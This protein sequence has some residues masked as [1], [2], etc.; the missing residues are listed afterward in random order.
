MEANRQQ[1]NKNYR[2]EKDYRPRTL[3]PAK[4]SFKLKGKLKHLL[5]NKN[6]KF[7]ASRTALQEITKAGLQAEMKRHQAGIQIHTKK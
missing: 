7:T 1:D 5:I 3:Y 6:I 2:K 4:L